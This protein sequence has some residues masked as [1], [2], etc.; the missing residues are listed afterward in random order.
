MNGNDS[1]MANNCDDAIMTGLGVY[2]VCIKML[3]GFGKVKT[4]SNILS[5]VYYEHMRHISKSRGR[6]MTTT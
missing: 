6:N 3:S 4:C 5:R 2:T 1:I